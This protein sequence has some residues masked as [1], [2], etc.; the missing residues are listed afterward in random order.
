MDP[1]ADAGLGTVDSPTVARSSLIAL[2]QI[3]ASRGWKI[4]AGD[5]QAAF[6]NGLELKRS[7]WMH[8]PR[9][10][11][12]GLDPRQILKIR[13]GVFGLSESPRMWYDRLCQVMLGETFEVV[14]ALAHWIPACS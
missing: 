13:K 3:A 12:E 2:L 8:Q 6:L 11:I 9:C 5:V 7:L 1:D 14:Y 10:G 4:A